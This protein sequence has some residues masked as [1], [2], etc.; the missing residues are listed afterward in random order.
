MNKLESIALNNQA[1]DLLRK[2][3]FYKGFEMLSHANACLNE[4]KYQ[5]PCNCR[6]SKGNTSSFNYHWMDFSSAGTV[7]R[8]S[9]SKSNDACMSFLC[10]FA[11]KI[12]YYSEDDVGCDSDCYCSIRWAVVYNLAVANHL[13]GIG[14]GERGRFLLET[15]HHFYTL[16][17]LNVPTDTSFHDVFRLLL[18][19]QNNQI[20]I[21]YEFGMHQESRSCL[22]ILTNIMLAL[23]QYT[24]RLDFD[25]EIL[26]NLMV[27]SRREVA[28]AA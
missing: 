7:E 4:D 23:P 24:E 27:L 3:C 12:S 9:E 5:M 19:T 25:H 15:A 6:H 2:G 1:V 14:Q 11:V 8:P 20:S 22:R 17:Q 26:L 10:L 18:A 16:A 13:I 28:A 21:Y